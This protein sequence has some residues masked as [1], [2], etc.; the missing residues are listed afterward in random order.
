M[1]LT[2]LRPNARTVK[3]SWHSSVAALPAVHRA[4]TPFHSREWAAAWQMVRTELVRGRHHLFLQDGTRQ[5]RMSFYQV[6]DSPLWRAMEGD[7]GVTRPTFEADVLYGP[8][9]YGEYG[10]LPGAPV[11]VLAETVDRGRHL[12]RE[13][14]TEALVI[15]NIPPAERSLWREA[16]TPD[17]EVVLSWAHRARVG[18]SVEEFIANFPSSSE[19]GREF[20]RQHQRGTD[21]GITLKVARGTEL[22]PYLPQ[23]TAQ[24]RAT[25]ERHGPALYGADMLTPLTRVPGAVGL[26]AEHA[27]GTLAGGFFAFRYGSALYLWAP[28]IHQARESDLHT[29]G[30]LMYESVQ[31][32]IAT[33]ASVLDAGRG[34]YA[35]KARLGM[36]PVALTSAV[37]LT[38][39][40]PHLISRLG[41]LHT[42]LNQHVLRAWNKA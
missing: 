19:A 10:G 40:N 27:D 17:A 6:S 24:A 35:Y 2:A 31:Y 42:G 39:P 11:P 32:A 14:G 37:Y 41:A 15:A 4:A 23:F 8:S 12:A 34:N 1:T 22:L 20:R 38:R 3:S 9:I 30:W 7:A 18:S 5:H 28:A 36:L 16:R 26:L 29:Y 13:L 25:S 21:A 33:G